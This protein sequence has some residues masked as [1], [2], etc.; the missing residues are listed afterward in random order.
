MTDTDGNLHFCTAMCSSLNRNYGINVALYIH[1]LVCKWF[2]LTKGFRIAPVDPL[3]WQPRHTCNGFNAILRGNSVCP[4]KV[5]VFVTDRLRFLLSMY[6]NKIEDSFWKQEYKSHQRRSLA[7][8]GLLLEE[9]DGGYSSQSWTEE[10]GVY[11]EVL[12]AKMY[13]QSPG[14]PYSQELLQ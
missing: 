4:R 13:F 10:F 14:Y 9:E 6:D 2:I 5:L 8:K 7:L 3:S 12:P 1:V 11:L